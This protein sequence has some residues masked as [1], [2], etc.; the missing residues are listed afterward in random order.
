MFDL[1]KE[2]ACWRETFSQSD[3]ISAS[4][5]DELESHLR[6]S[7]GELQ[8][9]LENPADAFLLATHRLGSCDDVDRE[10]SK[11]KPRTT[12]IPVSYTHLTLPTTPYV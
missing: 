7:F 4:E 8:V 11:I 5:L 6:D 3:S 1:N 2:I 9:Q 12:W 10:F